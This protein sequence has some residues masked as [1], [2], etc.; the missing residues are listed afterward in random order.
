MYLELDK[1]TDIFLML[2]DGELQ[3]SVS[4]FNMKTEV[5]P[6]CKQQTKQ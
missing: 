5:G 6:V 1:K 2:V 3:P 4:Y